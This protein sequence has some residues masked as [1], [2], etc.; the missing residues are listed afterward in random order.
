MKQKF[1]S[2]GH[3]PTLPNLSTKAKRAI[4]ATLSALSAYGSNISAQTAPSAINLNTGVANSSNSNGYNY[5]QGNNRFVNNLVISGQTFI[6]DPSEPRSSPVDKVVINRKPNSDANKV[7]YNKQTLFFERGS[8]NNNLQPNYIYYMEDMINSYIANRGSDNLFRNIDG[9]TY[10]NVERVDLLFTDGISINS[11]VDLT[12]IGMLIMERAPNTA[13]ADVFRFALIKGVNGTG[14][15]ATAYT[16]GELKSSQPGAVNDRWGST[17]QAIST[18]VMHTTSATA[19]LTQTSS[20]GD[21]YIV[22]TFISL[23]DLGFTNQNAEKFYG[24]SIFPNDFVPR[25]NN[26]DHGIIFGTS[27]D[28]ASS[29]Q[30]SFPTND[31]FNPTNS[32]QVA[33]REMTGYKSVTGDDYGGLDFTAGGSFIM[34]AY[35]SI[36]GNVWNDANGN[37][38]GNVDNSGNAIPSNLFVHLV[39]ANGAIVK[40]AP[41]NSNGT[42]A[43]LDVSLS[44]STNASLVLSSS[45]TSITTLPAGWQHTGENIGL[46]GSDGNANGVLALFSSGTGQLVMGQTVSN[47]N[48]GIQRIPVA[49]PKIYNN[50][51]ESSFGLDTPT[52]TYSSFPAQSGFKYMPMSNG[53]LGGLSGS[54]AEDCPSSSS[55]ANGSTFKIQAINSNTRL[56]YDFGALGI[57]RISSSDASTMQI[58]N[59]DRSK[60]M[61]Y[62]EG[63]SGTS[64]NPLGFTYSLVDNAGAESTPASYTMSTTSPLPVSLLNFTASLNSNGEAVLNWLTVSEKHNKGF[65]VEKSQNARQWTNIGFIP[66]QKADGNATEQLAYTFTDK[67]IVEGNCYYRLVTTDFDGKEFLSDVRIVISKNNASI[68]VFPNPV[69]KHLSIKGLNTQGQL[70]LYNMSGQLLL[71][72]TITENRY[73][74]DLSML[75]E[76]LYNIVVTV[77]GV[78]QVFKVQKIK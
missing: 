8:G 38:N 12:K 61:I 63:G 52:G 23:A 71:S 29:Q 21:Q 28:F 2:L 69:S 40:T 30:I 22:G 53:L 76:G 77:E 9:N 3:F 72:K 6:K 17:G 56:F 44:A 45:A 43:L 25:N 34:L 7:N 13:S 18:L 15:S 50:L 35:P 14:T 31:A 73:E 26:N 68:E 58:K 57:K 66:S 5:G 19:Q 1:T 59:F 41:V 70:K 39:N 54:D 55:C 47:A 36:T 60:M 67:K 10:N 16:F 74:L 49:D 27:G 37:T 42:Y 24:I 33:M 64:T 20:T 75:A 46:I 4:I 48:F 11:K 62:G 78:A 51:P 32:Y 65:G